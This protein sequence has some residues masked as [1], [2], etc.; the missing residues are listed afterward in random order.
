MS[1]HSSKFS[2]S[3]AHD[4][5]PGS[6]ISAETIR[7]CVLEA[8][9]SSSADDLLRCLAGSDWTREYALCR[10]GELL[11]EQLKTLILATPRDVGS[12]GCK[13]CKE[14]DAAVAFYK[15]QAN[16]SLNSAAGAAS[17]KSMAKQL[18]EAMFMKNSMEHQI[19]KL[20]EELHSS[21]E[22]V[23]QMKKERHKIEMDYGDIQKKLI[24]VNAKVQKITEDHERIASEKEQVQGEADKVEKL[25]KNER[26]RAAN[27]ER[28][29]EQVQ[30]TYTQLHKNSGAEISSLREH[31][32]LLKSDNL[33]LSTQVANLSADNNSKVDEEKKESSKLHKKVKDLECQLDGLKVVNESL[34]KKVDFYKEQLMKSNPKSTQIF[35]EYTP[36][37]LGKTNY[38]ENIPSQNQGLRAN[39]F[40]SFSSF[41]QKKVKEIN[42][43]VRETSNDKYD[44]YQK[45]S[46]TKQIQSLRAENERLKIKLNS[47]VMQVKHLKELFRVEVNTERQELKNMKS[48]LLNSFEG[49]S[50]KV[51]LHSRRFKVLLDKDMRQRGPPTTENSIRYVNYAEE[52]TY[53][54]GD[55]YS[56]P[57]RK[58]VKERVVH[59]YPA[60][61]REAKSPMRGQSAKII[62]DHPTTGSFKKFHNFGLPESSD[63]E[64]R[65]FRASSPSRSPAPI[66]PYRKRG[67]EDGHRRMASYK[68]S[69][70]D[71]EAL[72]ND[73]IQKLHRKF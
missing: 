3:G 46:S 53:N 70:N 72:G 42:L 60:Y 69:F 29:L 7:N 33:S 19:M 51:R 55:L 67:L 59:Q 23:T 1:V 2:A 12:A 52:A 25:Y 24:E 27:L 68:E 21:A 71:W 44:P 13:G 16:G 41:N 14:K 8:L 63:V 43:E 54:R 39:P 31:I 32:S 65:G 73:I 47:I 66:S 38:E 37:D 45:F 48:F 26:R 28:E 36:I 11:Q 61:Q 50:Q 5:R 6:F 30:Y 34:E 22:F 35:N 15:Q 57:R 18:E 40:E 56:P 10:V 58:E 20:K 17:N 62:Q 64:T 4:S 49:I 9:A